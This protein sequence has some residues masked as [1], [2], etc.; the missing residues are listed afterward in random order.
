MQ[1]VKF[2]IGKDGQIK[3]EGL[4]FEGKNC[5]EKTKAYIE[6]LGMQQKQELKAEFYMGEDAGVSVFNG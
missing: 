3:T 6:A 1:S 5:L 2:T 4:G